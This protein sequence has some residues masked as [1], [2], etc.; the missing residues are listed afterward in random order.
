[1][2]NALDWPSLPHSLLQ[3]SRLA[4]TTLKHIIFVV[5]EAF[6]HRTTGIADQVLWGGSEETF[7]QQLLKRGAPGGPFQLQ[8]AHHAA[9]T[10]QKGL[11]P[12]L[13]QF[14]PKPLAF[15]FPSF[16]CFCM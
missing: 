11:T 10:Y 15:F 7:T 3:Y 2:P 9:A 13:R 1:M 4:N 6:L 12:V 16:L 8:L 14:C 5:V